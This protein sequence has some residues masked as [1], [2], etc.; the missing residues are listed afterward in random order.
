[1]VSNN[2][3][4]KKWSEDPSKFSDEDKYR[5]KS[6]ELFTREQLDIKHRLGKIGITPYVEFNCGKSISEIVVGPCPYPDLAVSGIKSF[7]TLLIIVIIS[8]DTKLK[9]QGILFLC[10]FGE[11]PRMRCIYIVC[12]ILG[13]CSRREKS[14]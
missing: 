3:L 9:W 4:L 6:R 5:N 2:H 14:Y 1:M 10:S 7:Y 13:D 12:T 8:N 11:W